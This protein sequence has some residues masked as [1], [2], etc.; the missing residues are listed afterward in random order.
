MSISVTGSSNAP[1]DVY[2]GSYVGTGTYGSDNPISITFPFPVKAFFLVANKYSSS[3]YISPFMNASSNQYGN[4]YLP[5]DALTTSYQ[6][7]MQPSVYIM[8]GYPE[9][10]Y[11]KKSSDNKTITWYNTQ[12]AE[13]QR[14]YSGTT[15][16][17]YAI[18]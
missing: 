6:Q 18:R 3:A 7:K 2:V 5:L 16:Y 11:C 1:S 17:Y 10:G 14:N 12:S 4:T 13:Y 8:S 9:K 15:Y